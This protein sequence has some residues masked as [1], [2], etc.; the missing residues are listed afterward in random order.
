MSKHHPRQPAPEPAEPTELAEATEPDPDD[1]L[2]CMLHACYKG[3]GMTREQ[4]DEQ[5]EA[6]RLAT[7]K[8]K[9]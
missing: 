6:R 5:L 7:K 9:S 4:Y 2:G 8:D 3:G 1:S